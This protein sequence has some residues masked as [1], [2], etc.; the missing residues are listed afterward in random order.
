VPA[1][2]WVIAH[3]LGFRPAGVLISDPDGNPVEG[4]IAHLDGSTTTITFGLPISGIA[5]LS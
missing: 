2:H 1:A 3:H 5:D 4:V